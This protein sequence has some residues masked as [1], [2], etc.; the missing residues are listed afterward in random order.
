M[1]FQIFAPG[2]LGW[3]QPRHENKPGHH[4]RLM[5]C[6]KHNKSKLEVNWKQN[7]YGGKE[8]FRAFGIVRWTKV[9]HKA[10]LVKSGVGF[11]NTNPENILYPET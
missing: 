9:N 4:I 1:L 8:T 3:K 10:N 5:I 6:D 2:T 7:Y 11:V